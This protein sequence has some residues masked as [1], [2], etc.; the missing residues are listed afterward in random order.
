MTKAI[1]AVPVPPNLK[2]R[3][4]DRLAADRGA[5][6]RRRFYQVMAA[7][8]A[9]VI[10]IGIINRE[11]QSRVRVD[12]DE[13][14]KAEEDGNSRPK[15]DEWLALHGVRYSHPLDPKLLAFHGFADLQGK[16]VPML[17]YRSLD[18]NVFAKVFILKETDF[19]FSNLAQTTDPGGG[20]QI[21]SPRFGLRVEVLRD[22]EQPNKIAY[23][24]L[25][26]G[27]SL[28]PFLAQFQ[29]T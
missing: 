18:R 7:T 5:R 24:I 16:K 15:V 28:E 4:L 25:Y 1:K 14:V 10:A 20:S 2:G 27:D 21:I 22:R 13:F 17:Y 19:D 11:R 8:A 29:S 26:N 23:V 6:F 9:V 3:I 12:F